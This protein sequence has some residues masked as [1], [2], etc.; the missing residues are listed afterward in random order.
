MD[1]GILALDIDGTLTG[2]DH[3]IPSDV[4]EYLGRCQAEGWQLLFVTG[5]P[6]TFGS[7]PL[8]SLS[9]PFY[10]SF[11]NGAFLMKMPEK[12][13]LE[14]H[15]L[16]ATLFPP[17]VEFA[18]QE[19]LGVVLHVA[20]GLSEEVFYTPS[21]YAQEMLDYLK[22]RRE[23]TKEEWKAVDSI[24][25]SDFSSATY[26]KIFGPR[27]SLQLIAEKIVD[28]ALPLAFS[29]ITDPIGPPQALLLLTD[30]QGTKGEAL[31]SVRRR[32]K[33]GIAAIGAGDDM[34]DL[35][36]LEEAD[37]A[38]A[39]AGSPEPLCDIADCIA[40]S[41]EENGIILAIEK[42]RRKLGV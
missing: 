22:K 27:Y 31:R 20:S 38:I 12:E 37:F 15:P 23:V 26:A 39:I 41:T 40:E 10:F 9:F 17:L 14:E 35:S 32:S 16:S 6:F 13:V 21:A 42:A 33:K 3:K 28:K 4:M 8:R 34:N 2:K 30:P 1:Q 19:E 5:R 11:C 18:R 36:L 7:A 24:L 29:L 25:T